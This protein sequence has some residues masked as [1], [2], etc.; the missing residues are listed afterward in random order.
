MASGLSRTATFVL[1]V[2]VGPVPGLILILDSQD[3]IADGQV[4][5]NRQ[6]HQGARGLGANNLVM[7]GFPPDHAAKRDVT[8]EML[9]ATMG[10]GDGGGNFK[11]PGDKDTFITGT[12]TFKRPDGPGH[13]G[14]GKRFVKARLDNQEMSAHLVPITQKWPPA[15]HSDDASRQFQDR[16]H[17]G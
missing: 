15:R 13:L 6:I 5:G 12:G 14:I 10:E 9:R 8:V 4:V 1:A 11:R 7:R 16:S 2:L 3:A 17:Q